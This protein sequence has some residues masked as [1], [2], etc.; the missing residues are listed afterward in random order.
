MKPE[1]QRMTMINADLRA[2]PTYNLPPDVSVH[3]YEPGDEKSWLAIHDLADQYNKI[4]PEL[5]VD[6]FA[7]AGFDLAERQCYLLD[8]TGTPIATATAWGEH[9]GRFAR[10]GR[11]HWVAVVPSLQNQGIGKLVV[12]V[13]CQRL[14]ALG[15]TRAFLVTS[16]LRPVAIHLYEKFGFGIEDEK[17]RGNTLLQATA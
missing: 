5:F 9:E 3:W 7:D 16:H 10:F 13:A 14:I 6:Q 11:L 4:T 12:S 17:G 2:A 8:N 15:H 1:E